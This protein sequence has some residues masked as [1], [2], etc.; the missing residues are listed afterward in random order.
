MQESAKPDSDPREKFR[1][2]RARC[3]VG[4]LALKALTLLM[5]AAPQGMLS[6]FAYS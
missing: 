5:L 4:D 3:L 2:G 6:P 1:W